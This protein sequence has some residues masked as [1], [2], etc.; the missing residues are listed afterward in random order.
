M[1]LISAP[2]LF[3]SIIFLFIVACR[4]NVL[5]KSSD[6][7]S[8]LFPMGNV[9]SLLYDQGVDDA[10]IHMLRA[11]IMSHFSLPGEYP[12]AVIVGG[13]EK[14]EILNAYASSCDFYTAIIE[15][16]PQFVE[17][18]KSLLNTLAKC[19]Q[20]Y[21][22][23]YPF[24]LGERN[25]RMNVSYGTQSV[26]ESKRLDDLVQK[27]IRFLS[28]DTQGTEYEVMKGAAS[29]FKNN[30]I[31]IVQVEL[32]WPD[33]RTSAL[34]ILQFLDRNGFVMFDVV[35]GG[36]PRRG[37]GPSIW[38]NS[39]LTHWWGLPRPNRLDMWVQHFED[40]YQSTF[41]IYQTD[42]FCIHRNFL[43]QTHIKTLLNAPS[44]LSK[45]MIYRNIVG[46]ILTEERKQME[47][48]DAKYVGWFAS[49]GTV[50]EDGQ[51]LRSPSHKFTALLHHGELLLLKSEP[52]SNANIVGHV[53]AGNRVDGPCSLKNADSRWMIECSSHQG[54]FVTW[55]STESGESH[56]V[57]D[58]GGKLC[59]YAGSLP[60]Y[61]GRL[62][63]C[64]SSQDKPEVKRQR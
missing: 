17:I 50:V 61:A 23:I 13:G 28:L 44:L 43:S 52:P 14:E 46:K 49:H 47:L 58:D 62:Y 29:L 27:H 6:K 25:G 40:I 22:T 38:D 7:I 16:L 63:F 24:A 20:S 26:A 10:A 55:K 30:K 59:C 11:S 35:F 57:L 2:A 15:P 53:L 34:Q 60:K 19:A 12:L 39:R 37:T 1:K 64:L 54:Q 48:P 4:Y 36:K 42:I 51:W 31:D 21:V 56:L 18:Q 45:H 33:S 8:D 9:Q 41:E 5:L 32:C 3:V